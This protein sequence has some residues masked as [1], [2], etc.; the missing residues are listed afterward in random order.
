MSIESLVRHLGVVEDPR[1][2]GKIEHRLIDILV[3]AVCAVIAWD[4]S[5]SV[6]LPSVGARRRR[7]A[8]PHSRTLATAS[9]LI[10]S[11]VPCGCTCASR[12]ACET[13]RNSWPSGA[14]WSPTRASGAG[15]S[16][17]ARP[18]PEGCGP[19][20]PSRMDDGTLMRCSPTSVA[21]RCIS[22]GPSMLKAR[23]SGRAGQ[24]QAGPEGSSEAHA[25]APQEAGHGT[26][27]VGHGQVPRL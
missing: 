10:S 22:G 25:R 17:L 1:C 4:L 3:I 20:A 16:P 19:D 14:S 7:T 8:C 18:L 5:H 6:A 13:S 12:S 2:Q 21:N 26:R 9:H 24:V 15:C 23:S 27:R 11:S